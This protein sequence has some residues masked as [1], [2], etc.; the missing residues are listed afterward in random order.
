MRGVI[1][2]D[3]REA[4]ARIVHLAAEKIPPEREI[5]ATLNAGFSASRWPR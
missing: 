2:A 3:R 1:E 4:P 5:F